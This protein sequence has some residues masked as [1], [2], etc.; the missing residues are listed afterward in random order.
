MI[1][2]YALYIITFK[3]YNAEILL[4]ILYSLVVVILEERVLF[5]FLLFLLVLFLLPTSFSLHSYILF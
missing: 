4:L 5:R 2:D 3:Y 1:I